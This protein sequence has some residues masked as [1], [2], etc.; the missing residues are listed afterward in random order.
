M[1]SIK[2]SEQTTENNGRGKQ[3][4]IKIMHGNA[5][6]FRWP[7]KREAREEKVWRKHIMLMMIEF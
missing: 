6:A 2:M 4:L 5:L 1:P 7:D 3:I